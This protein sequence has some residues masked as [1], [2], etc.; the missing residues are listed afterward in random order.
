MT[1]PLLPPDNGFTLDQCRS[2]AADAREK[3]NSGSTV[4][5]AEFDPERIEWLIALVEQKRAPISVSDAMVERMAVA[6]FHAADRYLWGMQTDETKE[7]WRVVMRA[8]LAV[9]VGGGK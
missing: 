5:M 2:M 8:A 7:R 1:A 4:P 3:R 6:G 9:F